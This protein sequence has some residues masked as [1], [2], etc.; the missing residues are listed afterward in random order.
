MPPVA[1]RSQRRLGQHRAPASPCPASPAAAPPP[2]FP[3]AGGREHERAACP[4]LLHHLRG[5]EDHRGGSRVRGPAAGPP[6]RGH[7]PSES[8]G[9]RVFNVLLHWGAGRAREACERARSARPCTHSTRA[10]PVSCGTGP[11]RAQAKGLAEWASGQAQPGG[12]ARVPICIPPPGAVQHGA[13]QAQ[14]RGKWP[15]SLR[16]PRPEAAGR[17]L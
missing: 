7:V 15:L 13:H 14:L 1:P 8:L 9:R 16:R 2:P 12:H 5:S 10:R 6:C 11:W 4:S 3:P 17:R